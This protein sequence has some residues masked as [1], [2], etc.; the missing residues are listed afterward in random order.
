MNFFTS[1]TIVLLINLMS[2][3][4]FKTVLRLGKIKKTMDKAFWDGIM[5]NEAGEKRPCIIFFQRHGWSIMKF[6]P[7]G[8]IY[9]GICVV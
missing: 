6:I 9:A 2:L 1:I 3:M 7:Y 4:T 5:E 8:T